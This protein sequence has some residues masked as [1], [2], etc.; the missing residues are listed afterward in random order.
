MRGAA[1]LR[2]WVLGVTGAFLLGSGC[3]PT[4]TAQGLAQTSIQTVIQTLI[5]IFVQ[6]AVST[7]TT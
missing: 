7:V 5:S 4:T 1:C 2:L 3:I 6:Q